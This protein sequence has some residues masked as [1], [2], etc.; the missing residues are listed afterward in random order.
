MA[1]C[2]FYYEPADYTACAEHMAKALEGWFPE[3]A[4][5]VQPW[6]YHYRGHDIDALVEAIR[7]AHPDDFLPHH[8]K[9]LGARMGPVENICASLH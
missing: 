6:D 3:T 9:P 4:E 2:Y 1:E 8:F 7:N 5:S